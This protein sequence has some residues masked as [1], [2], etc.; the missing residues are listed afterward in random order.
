MRKSLRAGCAGVA[1]LVGAVLL[2]GAARAQQEE[3]APETE[4]RRLLIYRYKID[5]PQV[6][7]FEE[8]M[9]G[10]VA[11]AEEGK[12]WEEWAW[13][14][15]Q[16]DPFTYWIFSPLSDFRRLDPSSD[17]RKA[18][19]ENFLAKLAAER[20]RALQA[21]GELAI[22]TGESWVVESVP[23]L[24]YKPAS[25]KEEAETRYA[26]INVEQ[27][28][29]ER[30]ADYEEVVKRLLAML[31]RVE[32]PHPMNVYRSLTGPENTYYI[33]F[34]AR[35]REELFEHYRWADERLPAAVGEEAW[36]KW[37]AEWAACLRTF[38][39]YDETAR[40]D[41]SYRPSDAE[42]SEGKPS[43]EEDE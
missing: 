4:S 11:A 36:A 31:R 8:A 22:L 14:V 12:L 29:Y 41:L 34:P 33:V 39:H 37:R 5:P 35:D 26:H 7:T 21:K 9:R 24:S 28:R 30:V 40:P 15:G 38:K 17:F 20:V 32:F 42:A 25:E 19:E 10:W 3:A 27:V 1:L 2:S 16:E 18:L 6:G 43:S 13:E 23:E